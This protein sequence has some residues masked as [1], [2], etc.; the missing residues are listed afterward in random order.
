[1]QSVQSRLSTRTVIILLNINDL[2]NSSNVFVPIM[3]SDDTNLLCE[4]KN[5]ETLFKTVHDK[6]I[7][8]SKWSY[9]VVI[10]FKP[11]LEKI[12]KIHPEKIS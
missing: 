12:K 2:P 8:I 3:F 1:M 9:L 5:I 6:L 11:N 4:Y 7:K 10:Y